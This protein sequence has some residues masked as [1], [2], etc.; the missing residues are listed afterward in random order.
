[1]TPARESGR[2]GS[3]LRAQ[4][5][6]PRPL[7][8]EGRVVMKESLWRR[9]TRADG[10]CARGPTGQALPAPI[11]P[12]VSWVC[13]S[14]TTITPSKGVQQGAGFCTAPREASRLFERHYTLPWWRGLMAS[15]LA[16]SRWS[17]AVQEWRHL[18][19]A[20]AQECWW[21]RPVAAA[22]SS[23][24]GG[25]CRAFWRFEELAGMVSAPRGDSRG[26]ARVRRASLAQ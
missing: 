24:R 6:G 8:Q 11:G 3:V 21:P 16:R 12:T 25:G 20:R 23:V 13:R 2:P 22:E 4:W 9:L 10:A 5:R 26:S 14:P 17:P 15:D 18:H 7:W 19:W 1:M